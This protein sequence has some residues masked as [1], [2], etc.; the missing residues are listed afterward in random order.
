MT[1]QATVET[2]AQPPCQPAPAKHDTNPWAWRIVTGL[3][4]VV[5]R[6]WKPSWRGVTCTQRKQR[7]TSPLPDNRVW[8]AG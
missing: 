6:T 5:E 4:L 1:G 8:Q 3:L 7:A 2:T